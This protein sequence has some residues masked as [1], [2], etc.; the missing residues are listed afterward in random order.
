MRVW[1]ALVTMGIALVLMLAVPA[2][3]GSSATEHASLPLP[4]GRES[5]FL[6]LGVDDG[7]LSSTVLNVLQDRRGFVWF[8]TSNGLSRYDGYQFVNFRHQADNPNSLSSNNLFALLE[9]RDGLLWIGADPGGLNVYDPASGQFRVY[10]HDPNNPNSLPNDSVWSLLED[11]QGN[12][13]V[14]TRGGLSRFDPANQTFTNYKPDPDNPRALAAPVI[15]RLYQ[16][17]A[18][19]IWIAT[20]Q[21]LQRYNPETDDF[22]TFK[23]NPE[24]PA[25][26]SNNSVWAMLEDRQGNFWVATR[27]GGLNRMERASGKFQAYR[28]DPQ[29]ER[30]LSDDCLWY[31]YEDRA[32]HLWISTENGGLNLFDPASGDFTRFQHDPNNPF[33]ISHNDTYWITEDRSGVVWVTSRFGGVN[34]LVPVFQRF[35]IMR[36]IPGDRTSLSSSDVYSL[37]AAPDGRL[38][39][40]TFGGGLHLYD[41]QNNRMRVFRNEPD[42]PASLSNN[43][44]Y[45]LLLEGEN[46][47]WIGTSGGGLNRFDLTKGSFTAF[48]RDANN[49]DDPSSLR[50][51][52]IYSL[53]FDTSGNLWLGTLGFGL[54]RFDPRSGKV[55]ARYVHQ[56]ENPYSLSEDT[57]YDLVIDRAGMLWIAT[58]R[59]GVNYFDPSNEQF[60]HHRHDPANPASI[61]SNTVHALYLD[62]QAGL[63]WAA[64]AS[65]LSRLDLANQEWKNYG[66]RDGLP[67]DMVMSIL[68]DGRGSLWIGTASGLS[69]FDLASETFRNFDIQD[70]VHGNQFG[71][72]A[73]R[74]PRTGLLY[75]GGPTGLTYFN[76]AD[77]RVNPYLPD[78]VLTGF[79][80]FNQPVPAG[81]TLLPQPIEST[82]MV[83]LPHDQS[84]L[85][86]RFTSLN[87]QLPSKNLF[88][89]RLVGF[90]KDWS[91]PR[92]AR[93]ATY[94]NLAPGEYTFEVR[95]ANNDGL[96]GKPASLDIRILPPW[97][98]TTI[99]R[100]GLIFGVGGLIYIGVQ[101]RLRS[102]RRANRL[103]EKRVAERTAELEEE[104]QL[105]QQVE[106]QLREANAQLHAR[107]EEIT[108]LQ[109]ELRHRALHDALTGLY[110]RHHLAEVMTA[111]INRAGRGGY[112]ICFLLIDL[113][114]FKDINDT[115]G[116]L[117]GDQVLINMAQIIRDHT[118]QSD[119]CFRY[120]GEEFLV[121]LPNV[122][123]PNG[124]QRAEE[125]RT[126][127]ERSR[128]V[129]ANQ[130]IQLSASLGI[131]VYP[132]HGEDVDHLLSGLDEALYTAK[133]EGRNRAMIIGN[134]RPPQ[135]AP[136]E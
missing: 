105:R 89:Y 26:L 28:H 21:G 62:E 106:E 66:L 87:F 36:H 30:S 49:P 132:L 112:P 70:G 121:I 39:I 32:G 98:Q 41:P 117:A 48:Q 110:N 46:T 14:G 6:R 43:K 90:D 114:H 59:G 72:A 17:R 133:R 18:G 88:Q 76:P 4:F 51:N 3:R 94:T 120:G 104:I 93:E 64:T 124:I 113:D 2:S 22:T 12:I 92:R 47:L 45:D 25:S 33:S 61:A 78:V 57:I 73:A 50:T 56:P 135:A 1:S 101:L 31:L 79:E 8:A 115:H 71:S 19:V 16:D 118:R 42:N 35:G 27:C 13:W 80:L 95:S 69:R 38:W 68:P 37:I 53:A 44:I 111:E 60:S 82:S 9:S 84:V 5:R 125:I 103:L 75:L 40:G 99:F 55:T 97:W 102:I 85:T 54:D 20:R 129:F 29:N 123:L 108:A 86:L 58:A 11:Q 15:N 122:S 7:L 74:S 109:S 52:F 96:W 116:H 63:L 128:T 127:I 107:V 130:P 23:N 83:S 10:R 24:D 34:Q 136:A 100:L 131:A 65:G 77:L 119:S 67:S 126:A 81:S 91:P 134:T